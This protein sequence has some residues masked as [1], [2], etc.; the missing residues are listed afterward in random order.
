MTPTLSVIVPTCGR[1]S[2][3]RLLADLIPDL[4]EHDEVIV[5]GDGLQVP[6]KRIVVD[7]ADPHVRYAETPPT[8]CFG[9]AQRQYGM[10]LARSSHL[11]FVDDDDHVLIGGLRILRRLAARHPLTVIL[12][13]M[14]DKRGLLLWMHEEVKQGNVSSQ[15]ILVPNVPAALGV[16]GARYEGDYDFLAST[17]AYGWPVHWSPTIIT[18]CRP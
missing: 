6:A 10:T 11:C 8:Y 9:N 3:S 4:G 16:W 17:V 14:I 7:R 1:E 13:R 15:M 5:V 12:S 18:D 2:L